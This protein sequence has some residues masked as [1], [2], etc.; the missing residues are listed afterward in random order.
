MK[1]SPRQ[2]NR[3]GVGSLCAA[4]LYL[5]A[6]TLVVAQEA[7]IESLIIGDWVINEELSDDTDDQV[8]AAIEAGG[9]RGRSFFQRRKE[10]YYRGGPPEQELYDRISYDDVLRI[11]YT[12]PEFRFSYADGYQRIF[13]SDGRRRTTTAN[14]FYSEGG[15]DFSF[16]NWDRQRLIVEARPRDGGFTLETYSI[17]A[18]GNRLRIEMVIQPDSF[19]KQINLVRIFDRKLD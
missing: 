10:D 15:R 13:H 11:E 18:D 5:I 4:L 17:E 3:G 14:D 16:G 2:S 12:E 7:T 8:E 9:G 19:R 1:M 6:C